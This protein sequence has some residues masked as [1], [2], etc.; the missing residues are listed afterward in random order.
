MDSD[1]AWKRY[2]PLLWWILLILLLYFFIGFTNGSVGVKTCPDTM[3]GPEPNAS[4]LII[5][6]FGNPF[7]VYCWIEDPI[8]RR[9]ADRHVDVLRVEHYDN[10]YCTNLTKTYGIFAVPGFVFNITGGA[11]VTH[12]GFLK[13][14]YLSNVICETTGSC[15]GAGAGGTGSDGGSTA[16]LGTN[17]S[18]AT[19]INQ[20][21]TGG[22][23]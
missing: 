22:T 21:P 12:V 19:P 8:M 20:P 11:T 6:Y 23:S 7:C 5:R 13:E 14:I 17:S 4:R 10:R 9:L 1:T 18:L 2:L 16:A 3:S 15:D